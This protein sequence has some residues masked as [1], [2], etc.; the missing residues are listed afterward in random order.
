MGTGKGP[1]KGVDPNVIDRLKSFK[2]AS[3]LK[4]AAMNMLVKM[5]D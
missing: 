3:K 2:G 4:R 5:A 1:I